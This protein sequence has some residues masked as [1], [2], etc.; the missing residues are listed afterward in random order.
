MKTLHSKIISNNVL[1][2][3]KKKNQR[4]YDLKSKS[5]VKIS[6]IRWVFRPK[7]VRSISA[8]LQFQSQ[9]FVD[10]CQNFLELRLSKSRRR[11]ILKSPIRDRNPKK[12]ILKPKNPKNFKEFNINSNLLKFLRNP[13]VF[14][15]FLRKIWQKNEIYSKFFQSCKNLLNWKE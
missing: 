2:Y 7:F 1:K 15:D 11:S 12:L 9:Q 4:Y 10:R 5:A 8:G 14:S 6:F 3:N 13:Y